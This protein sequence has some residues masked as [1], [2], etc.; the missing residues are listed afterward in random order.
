MLVSEEGKE[1]VLCSREDGMG[2]GLLKELNFPVYIISSEVN[3]VVSQRAKKLSIEC[4][5]GV[6]DKA[7]IITELADQENI[8]LQEAIFVGNDINDIPALEIVGLPIIVK[9]SHDD[10]KAYAKYTT[11]KSGGNGA[12]GKSVTYCIK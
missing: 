12:V 11:K 2:I 5:Q 1:S 7:K 10:I 8:S 4:L 3:P 6:S 9:D